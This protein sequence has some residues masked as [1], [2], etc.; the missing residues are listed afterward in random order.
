M[1]TDD[2]GQPSYPI[3]KTPTV[4][5]PFA[6][7]PPITS[8]QDLVHDGIVDDD[9]IDEFLTDLCSSSS[10]EPETVGGPG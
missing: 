1:S 4:D 5:D 10:R 2:A 8:A 9:E 3:P 7:F 6:G